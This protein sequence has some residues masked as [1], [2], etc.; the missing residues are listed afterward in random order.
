MN[1]YV[2]VCVCVCACILRMY[3]QIALPDRDASKR[4]RLESSVAMAL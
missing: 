4:T 3:A 2:C 1:V